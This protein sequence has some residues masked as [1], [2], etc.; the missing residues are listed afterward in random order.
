MQAGRGRVGVHAQFRRECPG[1]CLVLHEGEVRLTLPAVAAHQPPV[2]VFPA[3]IA[4]DDP[5]AEC[6]AGGV[7]A[8]TEMEIAEA[9][10]RVEVGKPE[11]IAGKRRPL[12]VEVFGQEVATV[13]AIGGL[14]LP[15]CLVG[16]ARLLATAAVTDSALEL[17]DVQPHSQVGVDPVGAAAVQDHRGDRDGPQRASQPVDGDVKAVP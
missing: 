14:V 6:C 3:R 16:V 11:V 4:V 12:L 17:L 13:E 9:A 10:E 5:P 2:C 1:A 7:T 15:G 8:T